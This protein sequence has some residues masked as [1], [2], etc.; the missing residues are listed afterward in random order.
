MSAK[1]KALEI[2][3]PKSFRR[4]GLDETSEDETNS[5]KEEESEKIGEN[6]WNNDWMAEKN[7]CEEKERSIDVDI[8]TYLEEYDVISDDDLDF[9]EH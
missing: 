5:E 1:F 4:E 3:E 6:D 7:S 2:E 9:I 8:D